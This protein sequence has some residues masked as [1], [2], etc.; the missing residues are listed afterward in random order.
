MKKYLHFSIGLLMLI[1]FGCGFLKTFQHHDTTAFQVKLRQKTTAQKPRFETDF[2]SSK[3]HTQTHAASLVELKHGR[4]RAFWFSGTR[5]GAGDVQIHSAVFD[6]TKNTWSSENVVATRGDTETFLLRYIGKVGNPICG[7]APDGKLWLIYVTVSF[8]GWSGS[9]LTMKTSTDEGKTWSAARRIVTSPFLNVST[10][11]KGT[12]FFY[13]DGTMGLPVYHEFIYK[14]GEILHLDKTGK[15]IDLQRISAGPDRAL[16]PVML[17]KNASDAQVLMRNM[18]RRKVLRTIS[19]SSHDGGRSWTKPVYLPL[20]NP[21]SA[22]SAIMLPDHRILAVVN[23]QVRQGISKGRDALALV[24]SSDDGDSWKLLYRLEDQLAARKAPLHPTPY[25]Q[26]AKRLASRSANGMMRSELDAHAESAKSA[27]CSDDD[28]G[29]EFS[30]PYLI[31]AQNG[32]FHLVYT[33]NRSFIKH[34]W[35]NHAWIKQRLNQ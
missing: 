29:F 13:S 26:V 19:V 17:V 23:D 21:N 16:E 7:R 32:D 12:P 35:F 14:F 9:S 24:I 28:C 3:L 33:W 2:A 27:M 31:Q 18:G 34:V 8:G 4:L 22:L 11:V 1:A 15:V 5:E 10:L 6:P 20:L 25:F 30:Y